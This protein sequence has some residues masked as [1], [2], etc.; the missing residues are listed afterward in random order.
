MIAANVSLAVCLFSTAAH[1]TDVQVIGL[2][3]GKATLVIGAA[4]PRTLTAGDTSP[5]GV[6]LI[7]ANSEAAVVEVDGKR[8]TLALGTSYRGSPAPSEE[9]ALGRTVVLS[10]DS[11]G[12]FFA[13]GMINNTAAVRFL[14][15]TGASVISI[16]ADDA[17]RAGIKF[18]DGQR[19][20]TH[21]A[22]GVTPVYR[23]KLDTVKIGDITLYNVD[24]AVHMSGQLP[25]GLLGMSFLNRM[26][27]KREGS[28]LTLIRRY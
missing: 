11:R 15:D 25:I 8:R 4:K 2:M 21:T 20:F 6:R 17:Q 24:A 13:T 18:Q 26:E 1:A 5:E 19:A 16:S 23:V 27:M 14:V 3:N 12:H 10:A 22:A 9:S 7:S 28:S